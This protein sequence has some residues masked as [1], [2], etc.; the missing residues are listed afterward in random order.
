MAQ[1]LKYNLELDYTGYKEGLIYDADSIILAGK[2]SDELS[3]HRARK[4]WR[5]ILGSY[6]LLDEGRDY[7][8]WVRSDATARYFVVHCCFISACGRYA[9]WRLV[10]QQAPEAEA[11]LGESLQNHAIRRLLSVNKAS[12]ALSSKGTNLLIHSL[13]SQVDE[14]TKKTKNILARL[15][16]VFSKD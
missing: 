8:L 4:D 3:A 11:R 7:E 15:L 5:G 2:Y 10:N 13:Q 6:F 14:N 16:D 1:D 12:T 9:F